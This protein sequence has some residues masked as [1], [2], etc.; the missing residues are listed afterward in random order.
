MKTILITGGCG[1]IGSALIRHLVGQNLYRVINVDSLTYSASPAAL[2]SIQNQPGYVFEQETICNRAAIGTILS[3]H[4]P[5]A[6][7]HLAAESHVDRSIDGPAV[8]IET[9]IVGTFS[10]LEATLEYFRNLTASEKNS[11]RFYHI[12][13]DEVYGDLSDEGLFTEETPYQPS[14][15]YSASKAASDHLVKAWFRTYDLPIVMS[16]CSNNYGPFQFPEKLVP[17]M[18]LR[19]LNGESL[20]VYG[21]GSHIRDWIYVEDHVEGILAVIHRGRV[22]QT[23]NLGGNAEMRNIDMVSTLCNLLDTLV[24]K[25]DGRHYGDQITFVPDRPGHDRRYAI[26]ATKARNELGWTPKES[27]TTG[28]RKTIAF[29]LN[30]TA[31]WQ[32]ILAVRYDGKRLGTKPT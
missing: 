10:L 19:A 16:H 4:Q 31:W 13:T 28:L 30:N 15:P 12:S 7:I 27:I 29:Y 20:P 22:G 17:L 32:S 5:S 1:F 2:A 6:V 24:P 25:G 3:R 8:F 14:S 9:N 11:F 18:I 21:D 26:D 23:Y